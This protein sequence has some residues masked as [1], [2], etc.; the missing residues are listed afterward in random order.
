M[1]SVSISE[2]EPSQIDTATMTTVSIAVA[3]TARTAKILTTDVA[4]AYDYA[5]NL[6]T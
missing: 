1:C 5:Y 4:D 3:G 6:K 2:Q